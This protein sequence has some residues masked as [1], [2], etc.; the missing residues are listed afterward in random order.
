MT[1]QH[2]P[3]LL[4]EIIDYLNLKKGDNFIDCTFGQGGHVKAVLKNILPTGKI[5]G[6]DADEGGLNKF[7][8]E[9]IKLTENF[10]L[11][12]DNFVNLKNIYEQYFLYPVNGILYDLGLSSV[13]LDSSGRGFSFRY[14]EPLDMRFD[15]KQQRLTASEILNKYGPRALRRIF[16]DYGDIS[17]QKAKVVTEAIIKNRGRHKF[18]TTYDLVK[19]ILLSLYPDLA[20]QGDELNLIKPFKSKRR[21]IHPATLFFQALRIEVNNELKHLTDSLPQAIDILASG[22]R[23]A[24]ISF[25]SLEDRIVKNYFRG[26]AREGLVKILTKKPI[27]AGEQEIIENPRSRSAKLRVVEVIKT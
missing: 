10:I 25:H 5:L 7:K 15:A 1:A 27:M 11:I 22:G 12:N 21:G 23:L 3:V 16:V 14:N 24:V 13:E 20:E 17:K 2:I 19:V 18:E 6:I 9:N 26:L 8:K 4:E